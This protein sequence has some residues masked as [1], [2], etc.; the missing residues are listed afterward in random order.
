MKEFE[1]KILLL[2]TFADWIMEKIVS[3][4]QR[5]KFYFK[6]K[7]VLYRLECRKKAY[8]TLYECN[9]AGKPQMIVLSI[10]RPASIEKYLLK[11]GTFWDWAVKHSIE[12]VQRMIKFYKSLFQRLVR[13][14]KK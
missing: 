2:N 5:R 7:N 1:Q 14:R 11:G 6:H 9:N 8:L 10:T 4:L 13:R 3:H 12:E